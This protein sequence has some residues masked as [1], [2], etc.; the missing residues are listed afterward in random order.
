MESGKL[1]PD[2][3]FIMV[4]GLPRGGTS[5]VSRMLI[6]LG[7][8]MGEKFVNS[9]YYPN[10]EDQEFQRAIRNWSMLNTMRDRIESL[11]RVRDY[12]HKRLREVDG[13][14]GAKFPCVSNLWG[15]PGWDELPIHVVYVRRPLEEVIETDLKNY[16]GRNRD[17]VGRIKR[18]GE[19][20]RIWYAQQRFLDHYKP[21]VT[22]NHES[23]AESKVAMLHMGLFPNRKFCPDAAKSIAASCVENPDKW[24]VQE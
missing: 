4:L 20:G 18:A 22:L 24:R 3:K 19:I 13:P 9:N 17:D 15:V 11:K 10:W 14:V 5:L 2:R 16:T 1:M 12:M 8:N 6:E 21:R 7:V 23:P